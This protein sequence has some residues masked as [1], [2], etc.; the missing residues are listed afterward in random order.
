MNTEFIVA[1]QQI[2]NP[3]H[4]I[5]IGCSDY[6]TLSDSQTDQPRNRVE[7]N[8]LE[9]K[10]KANEMEITFQNTNVSSEPR[11]KDET[12]ILRETC[13]HLYYEE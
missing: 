12:S 5:N 9:N 10:L 8:K 4:L 11:S 13:R 6:C 1:A 7:T 3:Q 2:K